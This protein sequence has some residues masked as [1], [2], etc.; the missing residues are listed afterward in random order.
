MN[1]QNVKSLI[2]K[3]VGS[4]LEWKGGW[5]TFDFNNKNET[6][7]AELKSRRIRHDDYPTAILG[8]NKI[9]ACSNP[10]NSYWFFFNYTDGLYY[11]K[12][13]PDSFKRFVDAHY[14]RGARTAAL[15]YEQRCVF[16]PVDCLTKY[17]PCD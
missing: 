16:I 2:E 17:N 8:Y 3:I 13:S 12:Y 1:E 4:E 11:I 7:F 10:M 5:S 14:L 9:E 6:I 15:D